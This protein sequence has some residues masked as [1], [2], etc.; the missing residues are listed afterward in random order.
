LYSNT[1]GTYNEALG[2]NALYSSTTGSSNIGVGTNTLYSNT[3]GTGNVSVGDAAL[4]Y[5][6]AGSNGVAIG[7]NSQ[8]NANNTATPWTNTNTSVGYQSLQGSATPANNTGLSNTAVGYNT[9][10]NNSTGFSNTA[11]GMNALYSNT[12][13]SHNTATGDSA[14][15]KS[16]SDN[17]TA[18]GYMAGSSISSGGNNIVIGNNAQV[19]NPTLSNQLRLGDVNI[20][21]AGVQV[22]WTVT[23]DKRWKDKIIN[24]PYGLNMVNKLRPVDYVRKNNTNKTH[25]IGFIAQEVEKVLTDLG[26]DKQG[27]LTKDDSGYMSLRYNDFI[28]V[29]TKAIQEQQAQIEALKAKA[30]KV[31]DLQKQIDELKALIKRK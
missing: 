3:A 29:L 4:Y 9:L 18:L 15:Y 10:L 13:G 14:L 8:V 24:L 30:D 5:N 17:N 19:P 11:N 31:D 1:S 22:A 7:I 12:S 2:V 20:S 16:T 25:E 26:Y 6:V 21:Y 23:S 27:I 28:P